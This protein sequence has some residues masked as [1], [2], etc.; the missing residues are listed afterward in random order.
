V[1]DILR[2]LQKRW[3]KEAPLTVTRGKIHVYLGM[4]IDYSKEGQVAFTMFD[5]VNEIIEETPTSS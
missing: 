1:E 3:G 5:F 2:E 4:T